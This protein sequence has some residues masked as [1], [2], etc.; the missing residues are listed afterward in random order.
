MGRPKLNA[1]PVA[2]VATGAS[3]SPVAPKRNRLDPKA[4]AERIRASRPAANGLE[5]KMAYYG[6]NP[7]W[8]RRWVN[9]DN[10][11]ARIHEGYRHV[12]RDEV[13]MSDSIRFGNADVGNHVCVPVGGY[14]NLEPLKAYLMEI[15]QEIA[16]D[17]DYS[18]NYSKIARIED[19]IK[20][21]TIGIDDL[22]NMRIP[23]DVPISLT[24]K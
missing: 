2:Q 21:G 18:K 1:E 6:E 12:Q 14:V 11:P 15:P 23:A 22:R 17:L 13:D 16:N 20:K 10:V 3:A 5:Q 24:Q 19:T 8:K 7:G 9:A 4:E